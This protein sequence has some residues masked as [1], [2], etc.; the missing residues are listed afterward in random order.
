LEAITAEGRFVESEVRV[1]AQKQGAVL[2]ELIVIK[3]R[4]KSEIYS[5]LTPDQRE[6]LQ[7]LQAAIED[8]LQDLFNR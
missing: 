2:V 1:V 8:R 7:E 4:A 3:E 6:A 5:V